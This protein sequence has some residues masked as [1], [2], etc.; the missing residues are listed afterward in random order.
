VPQITPKMS[1]AYIYDCL[2][3]ATIQD[4]TVFTSRVPPRITKV[5]Q[6]VPKTLARSVYEC[7]YCRLLGA[8]E[9]RI[10][11]NRAGSDRTGAGL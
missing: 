2:A 8:T 6:G 9:T 5:A 3:Q 1:Q 7:T 4:E 11:Q 10:C